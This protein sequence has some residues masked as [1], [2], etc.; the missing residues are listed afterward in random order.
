[1]RT[2]LRGDIP[3]DH[4]Y[5]SF[6]KTHYLEFQG[7]KPVEWTLDGEFGGAYKAGSIEIHKKG[8]KDYASENRDL[9]RD[10]R[11]ALAGTK[12][13]PKSGRNEIIPLD[14]RDSFIS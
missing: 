1:M 6:F 11:S 5:V 3:E 10:E 9:N 12:E 7:E 2:L 13:S 8:S 14:F 4:P